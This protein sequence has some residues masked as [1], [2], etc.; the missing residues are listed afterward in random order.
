MHAQQRLRQQEKAPYPIST[1]SQ[2][3]ASPEHSSAWRKTSP[4]A[5]LLKRAQA[6]LLCRTWIADG[7]AWRSGFQ[8]PSFPCCSTRSPGKGGRADPDSAPNQKASRAWSQQILVCVIADTEESTQ[9]ILSAVP[10]G[11]DRRGGSG[12]SMGSGARHQNRTLFTHLG[13]QNCPQQESA[14]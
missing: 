9:C 2:K 14:H 11:V 6:R 3:K 8:A 4:R 5:W 10:A 1:V 12:L 13:T 7:K